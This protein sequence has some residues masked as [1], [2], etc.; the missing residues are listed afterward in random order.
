MTTSTHD[1]NDVETITAT[2]KNA[3]DVVTDP[4]TVTF[5]MREPDGIETPYVYLTDAEL[6]RDSE[7]VFHVD[8]PFT[9][10]GRHHARWK[11]T[12]A[13]AEAGESEYYVK[14]P[15]VVAT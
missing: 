12:G 8:W 2:F 5:V 15:R 13:V 10:A 3:A 11:G 9:K 7:G 4:T 6:V 14:R 1:I